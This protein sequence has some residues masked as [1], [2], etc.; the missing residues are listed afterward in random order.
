[1]KTPLKLIKKLPIRKRR[2]VMWTLAS[3]HGALYYGDGEKFLRRFDLGSLEETWKVSAGRVW[4]VC[5][6]EDVVFVTTRDGTDRGIHPRDG[7]E[8]WRQDLGLNWRVWR[9]HVLVG[10]GSRI[11]VL[12]IRTGRQVDEVDVGREAS[13]RGVFGDLL[14][15]SR[16]M[17]RDGTGGGDPISCFDL[18]ERR[19]VWERNLLADVKAEYGVETRIPAIG[20]VLGTEERFVAT[21]GGHTFGVSLDDGRILWCSPEDSLYAWPEVHGG[22]VF[23]LS[24]ERKDFFVTHFVALD[25]ATGETIYDVPM[26]NHSPPLVKKLG[27][28]QEPLVLEGHLA[29]ATEAGLLVT[30]RESDGQPVWHYRH[31]DSLY[32]GLVAAS[33][34]FVPSADG[35]ILVFEEGGVST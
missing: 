28:A 18:G 25:E 27:R 16:F 14:I 1:M 8:I 12:D 7:S 24:S 22:R 3:A 6:F 17:N 21:Y 19:P 15:L 26:T 5:A 34:A 23:M 32:S 9:D 13:L 4:V 35:N 31:R 20:F 11:E 10:R 33:R 29:Y 30:F 2:G